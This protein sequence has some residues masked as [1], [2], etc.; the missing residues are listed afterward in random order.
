ME[1]K[2]NY[3]LIGLFVLVLGIAGIFIPLWLSAGLKHQSYETYAIFMNESVDGLSL[4]A[5]VKYNGVDVGFVKAIRLNPKNTQQVQILANIKQGTPI[6]THTTASLNVQGL[7]GMAYIGLKGGQFEGATPLTV[8]PGHQY[9]IITAEPSLFKRL[10]S[11]VTQVAGNV[12]KLTGTLN[13]VLNKK[14]QQSLSNTIQNLDTVT[15]TL[16]RNS[17][18]I[19]QSLQSLNI[20]LQNGAQASGQLQVLMNQWQHIET[21]IQQ[22]PSILV[23]GKTPAKPG[24][25]E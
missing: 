8:Q 23:R 19:D 12:D 21:E 7:T 17:T 15:T 24:P 6:T 1:S 9:P 16:A 18:Q 13:N 2:I 10:D 11:I 14:N 3:A 5:P 20:L 22:N 25:G 4:N